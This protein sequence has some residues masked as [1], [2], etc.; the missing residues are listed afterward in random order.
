MVV[1]DGVQVRISNSLASSTQNVGK[2]KKLLFGEAA[3]T[4]TLTFLAQKVVLKNSYGPGLTYYL[5]ST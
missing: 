3:D 2:K 1:T 5:I 4:G